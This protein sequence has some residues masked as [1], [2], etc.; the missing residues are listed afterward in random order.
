MKVHTLDLGFQDTPGLIAAYLLESDGEFAL[1]ETGPGSCLP[2]ALAALAQLAVPVQAICKVFVSHVHLDH[3]GAAGWWAQQ[4]AQV[5]C[6]PRAARHLI[7]PSRL[8]DSAAQVYGD[9]METLWGEMLPAPSD[10][11]TVL[12]DGEQVTLGRI[13]VQAWD[14]PGHARHH[15]AFVVGQVCF[16]GDVAGVWL[17]RDP[18]CSVAAAPPQ[19][20]LAA[21]LDSVQRL[22]SAN[23]S[24]LYLT[25]FGEVTQVAAHLQAYTDR[26]NQVATAALEALA[27]G[28]QEDEWAKQFQKAEQALAQASGLS[29][30]QWQSYEKA[31]STPM[32]ATGLH[33]WAKA[34]TQ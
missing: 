25:H 29:A 10:K 24:K 31:N 5:F 6:H 20:E 14:T 1:I 33:Q 26:L 28:K 3:A 15:H 22:R 7:D 32:C 16:T 34:Q 9:Q 2:Q 23:F 8:L 27:Q 17:G 12:E 4:G 30:E 21:Y 13:Q 19:F 18:Y 11:V